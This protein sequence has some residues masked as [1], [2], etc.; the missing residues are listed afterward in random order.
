M[1]NLGFWIGRIA[2]AWLVLELTDSGTYLG[3]LAGVQFLPFLL[4]ILL[5]GAIADRFRKRSVLAI[6]NS[7]STFLNL[8]LG[9]LVIVDKVQIWHVMLIA[10]LQG[11][12]DG[13]DKPVRQSFVG[14]L[15]G[16]KDIS[17]AISLNS[18]NFNFG[19]IVGPA[20][21]GVLIATVGTGQAIA[22]NGVSFLFVLIAM[23]KVRESELFLPEN[24]SNKNTL[25]EVFEYV[26]QR[27]DLISIMGVCFFLGTFGLHFE[28][29]NILMTSREFN[30]GSESFGLLGT[31]LALGSFL[32][33]LVSPRLEKLHSAKFVIAGAILFSLLL[34]ISSMLPSFTSY[35]AI[36]PF[37][38][39]AALSTIIAANTMTQ[40]NSDYR[41]RGR[42]LGIYQFAF[43][44]GIPVSSP[45]IGWSAETLG[46]RTTIACCA[47]L[48]MVPICLLATSFR[49]KLTV[50]KDVAFEA[51]IDTRSRRMG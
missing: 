35:A 32:A 28:I 22:V 15:V 30:S 11:L 44:S 50:P 40:V 18:L 16:P 23:L 47:L 21:A 45:L 1:S 41:I 46:V 27:P 4:V 5:G 13:I 14:E 29:F 26:K 49:G 3:I 37:I 25:G 51:V 48:T 33:A 10:F 43:I 20:A 7:I 6:T 39:F 34:L 9:Y 31:C 12:S 42:V 36:L 38:G 17:N 2:Q 24:R 19:R 8:L